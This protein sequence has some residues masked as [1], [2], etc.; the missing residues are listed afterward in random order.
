MTVTIPIPV[1]EFTK[2][3]A[4]RRARLFDILPS[5]AAPLYLT[6]HGTSLVVGNRTYSPASA[7]EASAQ[8]E[9][10][11]GEDYDMSFTGALSSDKIRNVDLNNGVYRG[12][13]IIEKLVDWRYPAAGSIRSYTYYVE[14]IRWNGETFEVRLSGIQGK[15]RRSRG[16]FFTRQ[17]SVDLGS[18]HCGA[19]LQLT[20]FALIENVPI[21]EI[22]DDRRFRL[23]DALVP[24]GLGNDWFLWGKIEWR[25]GANRFRFGMVANYDD[26]TRT[27]TLAEPTVYPMSLTNGSNIPDRLNITAGCDKRTGTCGGRFNNFRNYQGMPFVRGS[28]QYFNTP[29]E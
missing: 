9:A 5:L 10:T 24:G 6:S 4:L 11:G 7:I 18:F 16:G 8:S 2:G 14:D 25:V 12:A 17:C 20:A 23:D 1:E 28:D 22:I 19:A 27:V 26:A 3:H 15:L 29:R 21:I 13:K